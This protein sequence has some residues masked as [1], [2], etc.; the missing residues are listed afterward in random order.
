[1][2]NYVL[3]PNQKHVGK[4]LARRSAY[5]IITDLLEYPGSRKFMQKKIGIMLRKELTLISSD[6]TK[7]ILG[8]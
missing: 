4:S 6:K 8:S 1:M 3:T 5:A 2:R 7:S